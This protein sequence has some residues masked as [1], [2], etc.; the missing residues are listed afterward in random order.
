LYGFIA[1]LSIIATIY[2]GVSTYKYSES[3]SFGFKGFFKAGND[4]GLTLLL[5]NCLAC[6]MY[7][8][9]SKIYYIIA[10]LLI[11]TGSIIIGTVAGLYGS[12][13][14]MACFA[15]IGFFKKRTKKKWHKLYFII[16][17]TLG[18][19]I[20]FNTIKYITTIDS[21]NENK[22]STER[23]LS[24]GA[25]SGLEESAIRIIKSYNVPDMVFGRGSSRTY[26]DMGKNLGYN[27]KAIEVDHYEL[28]CS[29]GLL[30]GGLF[31]IIPILITIKILKQLYK[32]KTSFYFW[33]F[34]ALSLFLVH[35]FTAGHAY[36]NLM[37]MS[38]VAAI[39]YCA[40]YNNKQ[41]I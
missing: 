22:F 6:Y 8:Y 40:M 19:A 41:L 27:T 25:R 37:A 21:Y 17:I 1:A 39:A 34:I 30:L 4:I 11:S 20:L 16:M 28:F 23:L 5:C 36:V 24:G 10:N 33:S 29:Y 7:I 12:A 13:F 3:Y 38:I 18:A 31:L 15:I 35:A 2:L 26:R 32:Y 9:T 14:V